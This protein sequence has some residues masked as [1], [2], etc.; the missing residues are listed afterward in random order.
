MQQLRSGDAFPGVVRDDAQ[1]FAA[2]SAQG[3]K[4]LRIDVI[5][6]EPGFQVFQALL[7][8]ERKQSRYRYGF[9]DG[10]GDCNCTTWLERLT[11]PLLSGSMEEFTALSGFV[12]FPKRRFGR[13]QYGE[14]RVVTVRRTRQ[15]RIPPEAML[16]ILA[17]R[18][19][20]T[21]DEV[22]REAITTEYATVVMRLIASGKWKDMPT[23]EDML[24]DERLPKAFFDYWEIPCPHERN[25]T[26]KG[27]RADPA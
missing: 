8:D 10:D 4:V 26:S 2:A 1:V 22:A 21:R 24:P 20:S 19:R 23:F 17:M 12:Y 3:L 5:L 9:P 27:E 15:K 14:R 18:F 11:L 16:S 25:G 7:T 6:P 13:C